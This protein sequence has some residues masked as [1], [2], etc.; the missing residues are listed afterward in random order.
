MKVGRIV[1]TAVGVLFVGTTAF[2]LQ[3]GRDTQQLI[4][5]YQNQTASLGQQAPDPMHAAEVKALRQL[6]DAL[7]AIP[8]APVVVKTS[9]TRIRSDAEAIEKS[10]PHAVHSDSAK[11]ALVSAANALDAL[12]ASTQGSSSLQERVSAA[13]SAIEQIEPNVHFLAQRQTIDRAFERIGDALAAAAPGQ[14]AVSEVEPGAE[15]QPPTEQAPTAQP[16][17]QPPPEEKQPVSGYETPPPQV[18]VVP[19]R[20]VPRFNISVGG[21]VVD[22]ADDAAK[23]LTHVGGMWDVRVLLGQNTLI[24]GEVAYVGTANSLNNVMSPFARNGDILGSG[25]E[26]NLRLQLPAGYFPVRPFAFYGI[27]WSHFNLVNENFRDPTAIRDNDDAFVMPFGGGIQVDLGSHAAL[28][29]RLTYRAMYDENLLHTSDNGVPGVNS[30]G[31]SQWAA[32][33]RLGYTF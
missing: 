32:S 22:F 20:P 10:T 5:E 33:A 19:S 30:Q 13:R 9:A 8:G 4:R 2:A 11:D 17:V 1:H 16:P 6:A 15:K 27:G 12:R 21:G 29:M 28:D 14:N 3:P 26:T 18:S 31:L 23:H 25:L 24:G 7:E